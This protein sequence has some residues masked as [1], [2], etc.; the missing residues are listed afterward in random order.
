MI[1]NLKANKFES[2]LNTYSKPKFLSKNKMVVI[3]LLAVCLIFICNPS[4]YAKSCLNTISVWSVKVLPVLFP[5]FIFTKIIVALI[6]PKQTKLDK[7]F[8]NIYHTPATSS[9]V[10]LLSLISGYPMG[11]KLVCDM[12][13]R[14]IYTQQDAKRMLAFCSVSG[15]MF[16]V[17]TVGV[18]VFG[19]I[20]FGIVIMFANILACLV[21]GLIFKGKKPQKFVLPS[22]T[23]PQNKQSNENV[24][25]NSVYDALISILMVGAFMVLAFLIIDVLKNTGILIFIAKV[26][27]KTTRLDANFVQALLTGSI[28][29]TRGVIDLTALACPMQLKLVFASCLI[30]F[31]GISIFMQSLSFSSELKIKPSYILLQKLV[32]GLLALAF[33]LPLSFLVC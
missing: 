23:M 22:A 9:S 10:F 20:K 33:A 30:G 28:E 26:V 8:F 7:V 16:M 3:L 14:G 27:E 15:P 12:F 11:A 31:G 32:Q 4:L 6:E 25:S 17:G 5:F 24:L 19:A 2:R 1:K 13:N 18:A 29:I 21:N